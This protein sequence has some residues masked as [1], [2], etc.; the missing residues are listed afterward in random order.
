MRIRTWSTVL[1]F[2]AVLLAFSVLINHEETPTCDCL[3]PGKNLYGVMENDSFCRIKEC[4]IPD[5]AEEH[6]P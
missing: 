2:L 3:I 6:A 1:L 5:R 4:I